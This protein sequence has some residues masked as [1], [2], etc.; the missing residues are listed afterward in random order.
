MYIQ[1]A[2]RGRGEI[3][4]VSSSLLRQGVVTVRVT[5]P[6]VSNGVRLV[7]AVGKV[8]TVEELGVTDGRI[9]GVPEIK[10]TWLVAVQRWRLHNQ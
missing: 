8:D 3:E 5:G 10:R 9:H 4:V 2:G 7:E 6:V 1:F